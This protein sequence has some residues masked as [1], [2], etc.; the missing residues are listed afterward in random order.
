MI[1]VVTDGNAIDSIV[2]PVATDNAPGVT[3][4]IVTAK[5]FALLAVLLV[6]TAVTITLA[7][8]KVS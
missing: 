3:F 8:R 5:A 4:C 6:M 1:C 2:A 7:A